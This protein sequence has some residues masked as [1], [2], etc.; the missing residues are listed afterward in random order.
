MKWKWTW[1]EV[2]YVFLCA[3]G[4]LIISKLIHNGV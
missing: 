2:L 3:G 1:K 4:I